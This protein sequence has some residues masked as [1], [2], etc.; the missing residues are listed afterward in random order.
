VR[1]H[2]VPTA[3]GGRD[4]LLVTVEVAVPP[5]VSGKERKAVEALAKAMASPR[6]HL[7]V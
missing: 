3:G 5:R 6:A 2:G 7:G 1:G 4:D